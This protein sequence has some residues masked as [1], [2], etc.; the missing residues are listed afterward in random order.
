VCKHSQVRHLKSHREPIHIQHEW[1]ILAPG[2]VDGM[3]WRSFDSVLCMCDGNRWVA[4]TIL[5]WMSYGASLYLHSVACLDILSRTCGMYTIILCFTRMETFARHIK[6][7]KAR[8]HL[9]YKSRYI[10]RNIACFTAKLQ[11]GVPSSM[12][13]IQC[14]ALLFPLLVTCPGTEK[15]LHVFI[16]TISTGTFIDHDPCFDNM[17]F[18]FGTPPNINHEHTPTSTQPNMASYI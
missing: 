1:H 7:N 3:R 5:S 14:S 16:D 8:G 12:P 11:Y 13:V 15:C 4:D 10:L 17:K 9:R 18:R 6:L 2:L